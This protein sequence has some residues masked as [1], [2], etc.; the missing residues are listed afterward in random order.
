MDE[1]SDS[2]GGSRRSRRGR[3][4]G[5]RP[6]SDSG[7]ATS[8]G[9]D[10]ESRSD[11]PSDV[12]SE[13]KRGSRSSRDRGRGRGGKRL[14]VPAAEREEVSEGD[15]D[16]DLADLLIPQVADVEEPS[17]VPEL[18]YD[19]ASDSALSPEG[20]TDASAAVVA[21]A[22]AKTESAPR[23]PRRRAAFVVHADRRSL[24]AGVLLARDVRLVEGIWVYPQAELMTFF[25]SVATDL[26][27]QTPIYVIGFTASPARDTI[28]AA[29]LYADRIDWFDHHD[30]PPE[31]LDS[32]RA[33]IGEQRV[34]VI[35][36]AESSIPAVLTQRS[37]R[38]RFSDKI[39]ELATGR[40]SQH[41]YERWGRVWWDR[42]GAAAEKHGE[43]KA[44]IDPLLV[45]RPSDLA[46]EAAD[47]ETPPPP[48]EVEFVSSRDFRLVHFGGYCMAIVPTPPEFDVHL[49]A[50]IA[51]ERYGAQLSLAFTEGEE[52]V[53]LAGDENS[54]GRNLNL[55]AM[56]SHVATKH[57]WIEAPQS[58]DYVARV[59]VR[60]LATEPDR[61]NDVIGEIAMGRSIL[62]G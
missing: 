38:S 25:R 37:R 15:A 46:S 40:F 47:V 52:V 24:I 48:H 7:D 57:E 39:V 29:S 43:R 45:G 21:V 18:V 53:I 54:S 23:R 36:G 50:R 62:E 31:D 27:E 13:S 19:D 28:Q 11:A 12:E 42:L 3:G 56:A 20:E 8:G 58:D 32:L 14:A 2:D 6:R 41:D 10:S 44:D 33:A 34:V 30:W 51:R 4:R 35:P 5:R 9:E 60:D 49:A 16:E 17:L 26:H 1:G 22:E 61:L 59:H 55:M